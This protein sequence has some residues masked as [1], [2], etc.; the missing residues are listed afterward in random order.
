MNQVQCVGWKPF[1]AHLP[2]RRASSLVATLKIQ[3]PAAKPSITEKPPAKSPREGL[4]RSAD[5]Q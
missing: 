4:S 5:V 1:S 2:D 3:D